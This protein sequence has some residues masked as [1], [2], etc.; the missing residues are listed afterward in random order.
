[1]H[2]IAAVL[3]NTGATQ[4]IS[5]TGVS[6]AQIAIELIHI[7]IRTFLTHIH[8]MCILEDLQRG[9]DLECTYVVVMEHKLPATASFGYSLQDSLSLERS[10]S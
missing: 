8:Q 2:S 7:S 9:H 10:I 3:G 1:M 4:P 6:L 5:S